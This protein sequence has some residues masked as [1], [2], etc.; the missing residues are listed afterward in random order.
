ML[1]STFQD[2]MKE[3]ETLKTRLNAILDYSKFLQDTVKEMAK[4]VQNIRSGEI[5]KIVIED[6]DE[7]LSKLF[8]LEKKNAPLVIPIGKMIFLDLFAEVKPILTT[9][10]Q[11]YG[12]P[13]IWCMLHN[14]IGNVEM[15]S[16][17]DSL[18]SGPVDGRISN[19]ST[20]I[21]VG[22]SMEG[23]EQSCSL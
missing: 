4:E 8:A 16:V 21:G 22:M 18:G 10:D 12:A 15:Y 3:R 17:L 9:F 23:I 7:F 13:Y 5:K 19:N 20:M 14:I 11:F 2:K 6:L 1:P